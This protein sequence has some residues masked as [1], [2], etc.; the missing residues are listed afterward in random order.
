MRTIVTFLSVT[1]LV[2]ISTKIVAAQTAPDSGVPENVYR[3]ELL[4]YPGPW[5]FQI[6][7]SAIILVRDDELETL[8]LDPDKAINLSTGG[9]PENQSLRQI[10]ARAQAGGQRT[11][12]LAFDHF[13]EQYRPGQD[14]PKRARRGFPRRW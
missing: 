10:C 9:P 8:A 3:G 4:T 13:F 6:P 14:T 12:I 11:L 5:G 1:A 2:L 7:R